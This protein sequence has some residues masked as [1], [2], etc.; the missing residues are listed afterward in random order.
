MSQSQPSKKAISAS[1]KEALIG[2]LIR[3]II[4]ADVKKHMIKRE[5]IV[6]NV[7]KDYRKNTALTTEVIDAA[8]KR[9]KA[10]FGFDMIEITK[11]DAETSDA[12]N[13]ASQRKKATNKGTGKYILVLSG[14]DIEERAVELTNKNPHDAAELGLLMVVLSLII[15][16]DNQLKEGELKQYLNSLGVRSGSRHPVFGDVDSAIDSLVK[17]NYIEKKKLTDERGADTT[18]YIYQR[19]PRTEKETQR[20]AIIKFLSQLTG[21]HID[22]ITL[23]ELDEQATQH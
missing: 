13:N 20:E 2:S 16:S 15:A 3:Y 1:E 14:N 8:K 12:N 21:E 5:D 6:K 11:K 7:M 22:E 9:I 23:R 19:G 17:H 18:T 10:I 4:F